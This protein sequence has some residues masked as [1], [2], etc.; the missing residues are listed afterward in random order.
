MA[1]NK[2]Q[3]QKGV[4][5]PQF[6]SLYVPRSSVS[7]R[8]LLGA[9]PVASV[10]LNGLVLNAAAQQRGSSNSAINATTKP[11]FQ[12]ARSSSRLNFPYAL[13]FWVSILLPKAR[14]ASPH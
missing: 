14:K 1:Q 5:L 3:F 9:S 2:V 11:P 10:F 4:S 8:Y 12:L 13:G 6:L 7:M